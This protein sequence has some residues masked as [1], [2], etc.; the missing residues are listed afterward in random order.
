MNRAQK[1]ACFNLFVAAL[2][3][4]VS[5][6]AVV[7]LALIVGLP[8]AWLGMSFM[9]IMGLMALGP[10]I[11]QEEKDQDKVKFDER[12]L[13]IQKRASLTGYSASYAFFVA[14]SM[15]AWSVVGKGGLVPRNLLPIMVCGGL[16]VLMVTQSISLMVQYSRGGKKK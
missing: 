1:I 14:F 3:I 6:G 13:L 5:C 2:S 9:G 8:K 7:I 12:D 15:V 4:G 10:I 11:F 16:F